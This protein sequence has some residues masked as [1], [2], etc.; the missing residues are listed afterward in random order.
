MEIKVLEYTKTKLRIEVKGEDH[1]LLNLL[2]KELYNDKALKYA[3]YKIAHVHVGIPELIIETESKD[4]KK[5][6]LEAV[7]RLKKLD[8]ELLSKFK[9]I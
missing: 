3:G 6:L 8:K 1:T 7:S 9:K 5:V 2:K 4:P